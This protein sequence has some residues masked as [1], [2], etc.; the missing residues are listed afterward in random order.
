MIL[1]VSGVAE[2]IPLPRD[3][4]SAV[5]YPALDGLYLLLGVTVTEGAAAIVVTF[6]GNSLRLVLLQQP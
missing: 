2:G 6:L 4:P 1:A 3:S 5:V